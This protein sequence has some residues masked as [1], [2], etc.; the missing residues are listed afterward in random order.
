LDAAIAAARQD[1][2]DI[3]T[4]AAECG[5]DP[6]TLETFYAWFARTEC[7]VTGFSQGVN[8]ATDGTDR[9]N[10]IINCHL[11]TGRI[12]RPGMGPFSLT[13]Q[14]NAMGGREVGGLANQLAA[15]MRFDQPDDVAALR[16]FWQAPR[17]ATQPGL[18]AV[19]LF[20]AVADGRVKALWIAATN[21]AASMPRADHVRAALRACP[22]VVVADCWPTDTTALADVV[23]PAAGWS[24]KDGTVTNSER[25]I[26]R[27]RPFRAPPGLAQPDWWMFAELARRLGWDA[28][29][30][31]QTPAAIFREHAALSAY[32]NEGRRRFDIGG[33]ATLND[34]E[35][36]SMKPV[37][38]PLPANAAGEGGRLFAAG[39]FATPDGRARMVPIRFRA[40]PRV[41]YVLNTGRVRDQWHTMTRTGQVPQL[42]AH[43]PEPMASI[44]PL[45]AATLGLEAGALARVA[46]EHGSVL[47]RVEP[48]HAQRRGELFAPM[49]WTREFASTGPVAQVV[50][51]E[52]DALSGQPALKATPARITA[53]ATQY[54][55]LLLRH[56]AAPPLAGV[57][58]VRIAVERGEMFR[59][60]GLDPLPAGAALDRFAASLLHAPGAELIEMVD[61]ARGVLRRAALRDGVLEAC[62]ILARNGVALPAETEFAALLGTVVP[63]AGRARL[64]AGRAAQAPEG[65][66]ICACLGITEAAIRHACV[67]NRLRSLAELSDLLGAG[68]SCGSCVPEL[69][70]I[71]RDVRIPAS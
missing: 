53:V 25:S 55:G 58:W 19:E 61:A 20:D 2:P 69:E 42:A 44:N 60:T 4:V 12:G 70:K 68:T 18:K 5:I 63:P 14:P 51:A 10:A 46:T 33:L 50:G 37:R 40:A 11:A 45:D 57:H 23:L 7:V 64:L 27:Q 66:R 49:H 22:F 28:A 24:E 26:T 30:A 15:H 9:V 34:A 17:L 6:E 43:T 38:W 59:L 65:P 52:C 62:V 47:L 67:A 8:Q 3:D 56:H 32:A 41:P 35:Y 16:K 36:D 29:F 71:L 1:A 54:R 48:N 21:P 31:W 13:G 39:G